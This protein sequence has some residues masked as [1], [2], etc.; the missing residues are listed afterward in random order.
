[1]TLKKIAKKEVIFKKDCTKKEVTIKTNYKK[2]KVTLKILQKEKVS[3]KIF[4]KEES[5]TFCLWPAVQ[6]AGGRNQC[7][8]YTSANPHAPCVADRRYLRYCKMVIFLRKS[9]FLSL[10]LFCRGP[11]TLSILMANFAQCHCCWNFLCF[12]FWTLHWVVEVFK[13]FFGKSIFCESLLVYAAYRWLRTK[14]R[15]NITFPILQ[16]LLCSHI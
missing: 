10:S 8:D 16:Q 13:T 6:S 3:L 14:S 12:V 4:Q 1:M 7:S 15:P 9:L 2:R 11:G 5:G